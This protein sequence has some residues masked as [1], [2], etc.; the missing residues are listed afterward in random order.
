MRKYWGSLPEKGS[1]LPR[2]E[3]THAFTSV[4]APGISLSPRLLQ[5]WPLG[6]SGVPAPHPAWRGLS[7]SPSHAHASPHHQELQA[8]LQPGPTAGCACCQRRHDF[9][10]LGRNR[11]SSISCL[12]TPFSQRRSVCLSIHLSIHHLSTY[13]LASLPTIYPSTCCHIHHLFLSLYCL[14]IYLSP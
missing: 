3:L 6:S 1:L 14:H 8:C 9:R 12:S 10:T 13:L 2:D 4:W 7:S 5:P 11:G